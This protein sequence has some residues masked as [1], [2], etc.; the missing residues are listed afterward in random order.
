MRLTRE[1][2]DA[3]GRYNE[4]A[5]VGRTAAYLRERFP[6][7]LRTR[8]VAADRVE[9]FVRESMA[10]AAAYQVVCDADIRWYCECRLELG[11]AFDRDGKLA[12][13]SEILKR[14]DL[15]GSQKMDL[16]AERMA[17]ETRPA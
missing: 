4:D 3:F 10:R 16:L 12:W 14:N 17:W 7:L 6:E 8:G 5:F 9:L 1:Q 15:S 2:L 13:P 11:M